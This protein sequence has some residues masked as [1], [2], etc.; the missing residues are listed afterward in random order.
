[1]VCFYIV[2]WFYQIPSFLC[3]LENEKNKFY[4]YL[5]QNKLDY[6]IKLFFLIKTTNIFILYFLCNIIIISLDNF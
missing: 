5:L 3:I 2:R 1:M 4:T 6:K